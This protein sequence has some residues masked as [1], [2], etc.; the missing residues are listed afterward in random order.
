MTSPQEQRIPLTDAA[1]GRLA[2]M[3]M[4]G[5]LK[6][7]DPIRILKLSATL[8]F[9]PT[10]VREALQLLAGDNLVERLPMRGFIVSHPLSGEDVLKLKHVRMILEPEIASMAATNITPRL[11]EELQANVQATEGTPVGPAY[12]EYKEYLRLSAEFHTLLAAASGNRFMTTALEALPIHFQR[13]RLFG[14][15]GVTDVDVSVSEHRAILDAVRS[16]N[17][18]AA[19]MAMADHIRGVGSRSE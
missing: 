14:E 17:P 11:L 13:F 7:G 2:E 1:Y 5:T 15:A 6:P 8:G 18:G 10:P 16:G 9:S 19:R 12:E 4:D 3:I